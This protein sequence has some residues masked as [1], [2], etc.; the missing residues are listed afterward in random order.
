MLQRLWS[1]SQVFTRRCF[2]TNAVP[3][4][5]TIVKHPVHPDMRPVGASLL[6]NQFA[7]IQLGGTQHKVTKVRQRSYYRSI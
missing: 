5:T 3:C 1:Q 7:V 4:Q 2:A 6:E